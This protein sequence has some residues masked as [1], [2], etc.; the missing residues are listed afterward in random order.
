MFPSTPEEVL[1]SVVSFSIAEHSVSDS[2]HSKGVTAL[3]GDK[4]MEWMCLRGYLQSKK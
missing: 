1:L 2:V 4:Q 3:A